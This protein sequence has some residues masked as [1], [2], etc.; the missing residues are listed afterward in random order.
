MQLRISM[1]HVKILQC[2]T[3]LKRDQAHFALRL[4][5]YGFISP[6]DHRIM[7]SA[8][9]ISIFNSSFRDL[10]V[11]VMLDEQCGAAA[12]HLI[13]MLMLLQH[14]LWTDCDQD[15]FEGDSLLVARVS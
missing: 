6:P 10:D 7:L 4:Y 5:R 2:G 14:L 9:Y 1:V 13:L 12:P 15:S 3:V 11:D 8:L